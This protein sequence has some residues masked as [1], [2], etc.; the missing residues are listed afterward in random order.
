MGINNLNTPDFFAGINSNK[1]AKKYW[2]KLAKENH[3]NKGGNI[4]I[5]QKINYQYFNWQNINNPNYLERKWEAD[6]K[7]YIKMIEKT[8]SD[9]NWLTYIQHQSIVDLVSIIIAKKT[10]EI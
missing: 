4:E 2:I 7:D 3:P 9:Y 1:K 5:M 10:F 8:Y 6:V